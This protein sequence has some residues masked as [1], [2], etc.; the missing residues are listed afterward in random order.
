MTKEEYVTYITKRVCEMDDV[1]RL[2]RI[3]NYVM[4]EHRKDSGRM[5]ARS[6]PDAIG[7]AKKLTTRIRVSYNGEA[8]LL[9]LLKVL[10]EPTG[11]VKRKKKGEYSLAYIDI[12]SEDLYAIFATKNVREPA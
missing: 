3:L 12:K 6:D 8:E 9:G 5:E 10:P 1:G 7:Q 11:R 4:K 2:N